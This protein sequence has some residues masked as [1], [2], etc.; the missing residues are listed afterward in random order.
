MHFNRR[1]RHAGRSTCS[2]SNQRGNEGFWRSRAERE[3]T[4]PK[5]SVSMTGA[6]DEAGAGT[7]PAGG[8]IVRPIRSPNNTISMECSSALGEYHSIAH[9]RRRSGVRYPARVGLSHE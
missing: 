6:D 7:R 8:K 4:A 2:A 5:I 1:F 3:P 9:R